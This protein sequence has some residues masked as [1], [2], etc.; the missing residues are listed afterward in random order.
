MNTIQSSHSPVLNYT[1]ITDLPISNSNKTIEEIQTKLE[2]G[3]SIL[4]DENSLDAVTATHKKNVTSL[5]KL[6][7]SGQI[8][9]S[10]VSITGRY[11]DINNH[12]KEKNIDQ[13]RT[14]G[15]VISYNGK[16]LLKTIFTA[17]KINYELG[18]GYSIMTTFAIKCYEEFY[19]LCSDTGIADYSN[20]SRL[21]A[22]AE[23]SNAIKKVFLSIPINPTITE[24]PNANKKVFLNITINPTLTERL[25]ATKR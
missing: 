5:L 10:D 6:L 9:H 15:F 20:T 2:L 19:N 1:C 7:K 17:K 16:E 4:N 14:Y 24:R 11:N 22:T 8:I 23:R 25:V 21:I 13:L 12:P 18:K 3:L